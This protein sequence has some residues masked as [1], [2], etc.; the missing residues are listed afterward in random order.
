VSV[1]VGQQDVY[2]RSWIPAANGPDDR[3]RHQGIADALGTEQEDGRVGG[4]RDRVLGTLD[5]RPREASPAQEQQLADP[6]FQLLEGFNGHSHT[7]RR[8]RKGIHP[9]AGVAALG[10][11]TSNPHDRRVGRGHSTGHGCRE[12]GR[13]RREL[14]LPAMTAPAMLLTATPRP[15]TS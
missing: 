5:E 14:F 12:G 6:S 15:D 13:R 9:G 2:R 3:D 1:G 8:S 11:Y 7:S 4:K 10:T